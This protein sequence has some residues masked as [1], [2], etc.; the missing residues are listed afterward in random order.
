MS[1]KFTFEVGRQ[2][3]QEVGSNPVTGNLEDVIVRSR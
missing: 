1:K 3:C 2:I